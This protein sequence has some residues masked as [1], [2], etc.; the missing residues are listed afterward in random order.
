MIM[1]RSNNNEREKRDTIRA[2]GWLSPLS[3][4]PTHNKI[5]DNN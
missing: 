2:D 1:I 5:G 4:Y 3:R